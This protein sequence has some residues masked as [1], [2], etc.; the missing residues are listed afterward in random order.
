M[1]Y[2]E[3]CDLFKYAFISDSSNNL[4]E[5][6]SYCVR[7]GKKI[8]FVWQLIK[9]STCGGTRT[10]CTNNANSKIRPLNNNCSK[11]GSS[12]YRVEI[13]KNIKLS[14]I[15]LAISSKIVSYG[16]NFPIIVG[17][18]IEQTEITIEPICKNELKSFDI[19]SKKIYGT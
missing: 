9:C 14:E 2:W 18:N 10:P 17:S 5:Q 3:E 16:I 8:D 12:K 11:C 15:D 4:F 7:C 6:N 1:G 13:S 19:W